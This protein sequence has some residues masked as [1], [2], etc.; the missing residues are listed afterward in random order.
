VH[1]KDLK[2][3]LT[4]PEF[5]KLPEDAFKELGN[6]IIPMEPVIEASAA[7]G[8]THAHVE[9]DQSPDPLAS[10]G[11]SMHPR[12]GDDA[13]TLLKSSDLAMYRAKEHGR[14]RLQLF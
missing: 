10:I 7:A 11:M 9:Q 6:G 3:G 13:R 8:V 14:N 4:L 12:D 2:E 1:L 5:G